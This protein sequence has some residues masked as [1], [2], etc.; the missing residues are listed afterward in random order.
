MGDDLWQ[1]FLRAEREMEAE[2]RDVVEEVG[3]Y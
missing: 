3:D 2:L 1:R